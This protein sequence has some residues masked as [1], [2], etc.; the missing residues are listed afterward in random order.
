M[1]G[2]GLQPA[3]RHVANSAGVMDRPEIREGL[4]LNLVRPGL[5]LYGAA[6]A[7]WLQGKVT[8]RPVLTWKTGVAHLKSVPAGTPISYGSTWRAPRPS[9]IA[10]LPVGYADGYARSLSN[11]ASVLVRGRRAPVVGRVCMDMT[12]ADV[13]DVPGVAVHDEVVLLGRQGPEEISADALAS[14]EGTISYEVLCALG[15]RVPRVVLGE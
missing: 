9:L 12:M 7:P 11:K 6:P 15:A 8:L 2:S 10:T 13:T 5:M 1:E 3:W 4:S 14:L